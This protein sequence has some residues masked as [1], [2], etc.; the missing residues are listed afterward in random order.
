MGRQ[1]PP[2]LDGAV[3]PGCE[4][5]LLGAVPYMKIWFHEMKKHFPDIHVAWAFRGEKDQ[6]AEFLS[7]RSR[8][9]W[10]FSR[11]NRLDKDGNQ[12]SEALDIFQQVN[13]KGLWDPGTNYRINKKS[14]ELGFGVKWGGEFKTLGDSGHFEVLAEDPF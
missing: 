9:R 4:S 11:H 10:P 1:H 14:K 3:C 6:N 5:R 7:G 13:G 2:H 8:L 12:A